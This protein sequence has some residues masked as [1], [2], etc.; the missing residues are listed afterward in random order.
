MGWGK[1]S[2]QQVSCQ[3]LDTII[4]NHGLAG[5]DLLCHFRRLLGS[6]DP[7]TPNSGSIKITLNVLSDLKHELRCKMGRKDIW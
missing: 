4:L 3:F 1:V 7:R 5:S 6:V 2:D